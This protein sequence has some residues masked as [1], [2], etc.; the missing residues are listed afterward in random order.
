MWSGFFVC[1]VYFCQCRHLLKTA[2]STWNWHSV[3]TVDMQLAT[4]T[5]ADY[6]NRKLVRVVRHA[7]LCIRLHTGSWYQSFLFGA[8]T[9][10]CELF[11]SKMAQGKDQS[12]AV[13]LFNKCRKSSQDT[14]AGESEVFHISE[15]TIMWD[16]SSKCKVAFTPM[17]CLQIFGILSGAS[18]YLHSSC[19]LHYKALWSPSNVPSGAGL[20]VWFM[21]FTD[22]ISQII[23][24]CYVFIS[25]SLCVAFT[26]L[27]SQ[28]LFLKHFFI[29]VSSSLSLLLIS[30]HVGKCSCKPL[31][32]CRDFWYA[33]FSEP[34]QVTEGLVWVSHTHYQIQSK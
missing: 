17:M 29:N 33:H 25:V 23:P 27:E 1:C 28:M 11:H 9:V 16:K 15:F 20:W 13:R 10:V 2:I 3:A 24:L 31:V 6:L 14:K 22:Y 19:C 5:E 4:E 18:L 8:K 12:F 32:N 7:L 34:F 26:P 21:L 30:I